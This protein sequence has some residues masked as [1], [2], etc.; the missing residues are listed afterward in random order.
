MNVSVHSS[1]QSFLLAASLSSTTVHNYFTVTVTSPA[2]AEDEPCLIRAACRYCSDLSACSPQ[3]ESL[4]ELDAQNATMH[5]AQVEYTCPRG[6][7]FEPQKPC[8]G[9]GKDGTWQA[10]GNGECCSNTEHGPCAEGEGDCDGDDDCA[11]DL[12]CGT[13]NCLWGDGDDCCTTSTTAGDEKHNTIGIFKDLT[14]PY[15]TF[16]NLVL[17]TPRNFP[18]ARL[19]TFGLKLWR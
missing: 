18:S 16:P 11:G 2:E 1:A 5:R 10:T 4:N 8:S 9:N 12:V 13:D 17:E 3:M 7:E 14:G 15:H 19:T 6:M